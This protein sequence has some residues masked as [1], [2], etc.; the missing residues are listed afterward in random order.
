MC[1]AGS[2]VA[3][4]AAGSGGTPRT[5]CGPTPLTAE[6]KHWTQRWCREA[7]AQAAMELAPSREAS[8]GGAADPGPRGLG[9]RQGGSRGGQ[10]PHVP[11]A[12]KLRGF[13]CGSGRW[14]WAQGDPDGHTPHGSSGPWLCSLSRGE[15]QGSC[16]DPPAPL[17]AGH[18]VHGD[19]R[20]PHARRGSH[21]S[22]KFQ[23]REK[24]GFKQISYK[25]HRQ[26]NHLETI[27]SDFLQLVPSLRVSPQEARRSDSGRWA[28][29]R[30]Q[31][32]KPQGE[33]TRHPCPESGAG[34]SA[35]CQRILDPVTSPLSWHAGREA[36]VPSLTSSGLN[37]GIIFHDRLH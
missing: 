15:R 19:T 34:P 25:G 29:P 26:S 16:S 28:P 8:A 32:A 31:G 5:G 23:S 12:S 22:P 3:G 2:A 27:G 24:S 7:R 36:P 1:A 10:S 13:Q 35:H 21:L 37:I 33:T 18:R 9:P 30:V 17:G 20:G 6:A 11:P 4:R 14:G